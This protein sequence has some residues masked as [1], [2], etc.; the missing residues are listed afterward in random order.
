[1]RL[2]GSFAHLEQGEFYLYSTDYGLDRIDTLRIQQGKF[3]YQMP[4]EKSATLHLL[5]PNYSQLTIFATS[6]DDIL[7]DGDAQNLSQVKVSGSKD[8]ELYT[9]FRRDIGEKGAAQ[10]RDIARQYILAHPRLNVSRYLFTEYFLSQDTLRDEVIEIYDSLCHAL[11]EDF[12]LSRLSAAVRSHGL[13]AAGR[14]LPPFEWKMQITD[15]GAARDTLVRSADYEGRYLLI[16][17]WAGWKNGS[18][19]AHYLARKLRREMQE[20]L[21]VLS[22]SLDYSGRHLE[23]SE[24]R[25]SINYP[26][27]CDFLCW[28]SPYVQQWG[29]RHLPYYILVGPDQRILAS[30]I[31][32]QKD[33]A[34]ETK[35][36]CL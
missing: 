1:M 7:I 2:K 11:P 5:Y 27:Y 15:G 23:F 8:N 19:R 10:V 25:D 31:N 36:L 26:N 29:I 35:K 32:W 34:P 13:L 21:H 22:Y 28:G 18:Q 14:P 33:I 16:I 4:L 9:Q 24:Q 17:F 30:G 3:Q 12:E 6:G 20:P